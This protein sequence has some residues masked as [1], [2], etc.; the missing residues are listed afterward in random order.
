MLGLWLGTLGL[1]GA[2]GRLLVGIRGKI[3]CLRF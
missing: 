2:E 1:M 3:I